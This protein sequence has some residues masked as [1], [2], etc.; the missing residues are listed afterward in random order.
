MPPAGFGL[1]PVRS[2][3]LRESS[4][5][6]GVL[7]C[8]SSPGALPGS[9]LGARPCAGRVAPFGYPWI[10]GCQRLP[11]AFRRVA[12][13][14]L[15]R[16]RQGIHHAPFLRIPVSVHIQHASLRRHQTGARQRD[17]PH[18]ALRQPDATNDRRLDG[19]VRTLRPVV[20]SHLGSL[21]PPKVGNRFD[22]QDIQLLL[23]MFTC[24]ARG[25]SGTKAWDR[26][27]GRPSAA[28]EP[29][30]FRVAH[31]Q[32]ARSLGHLTNMMNHDRDAD[33]RKG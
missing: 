27:T 13:S 15:G 6:L 32:G 20:P 17:M 28:A 12:A 30:R 14:F 2:P 31:C 3:L 9:L 21:S 24:S 22:L 26:P 8:F 10:S 29:Y 16:Q 25:R 5:F 23:L 33:D 19:P 1:L 7:R 11:R 4:L 18:L